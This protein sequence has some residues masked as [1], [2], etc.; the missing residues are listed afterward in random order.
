M[1]SSSSTWSSSWG[2]DDASSTTDDSGT[3][4]KGATKTVVEERCKTDPN[5]GETR[6]EKIRRLFRQTRPGGPM[7]E[8]ESSRTESNGPSDGNDKQ[9]S[10]LFSAPENDG[11]SDALM[12]VQDSKPQRSPFAGWFD[13]RKKYGDNIN[14]I[15]EW[16]SFQ[17]HI[18][19]S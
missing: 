10:S 4:F 5:S 15:A 19:T 3:A 18:Y 2:S 1:W 8:V 6:C 9:W 16:V 12:N 13:A 11:D 14:Y 7:E 17:I